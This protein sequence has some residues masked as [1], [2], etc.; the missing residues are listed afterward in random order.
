MLK[1]TAGS[2]ADVVWGGLIGALVW[3]LLAQWTKASPFFVAFFVSMGWFIGSL[4]GSSNDD[5]EQAFAEEALGQT[6]Q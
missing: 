5:K 2:D 6:R 3:S 1:C 4:L